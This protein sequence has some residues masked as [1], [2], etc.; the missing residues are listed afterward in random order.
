[1]VK[2]AT[3]ENS[4]QELELMV[5]DAENILQLLGLP[6]RVISLCTGDIGFSSCKTYDL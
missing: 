4:Q 5:Q 6:Y 3:P 1:M 2:F